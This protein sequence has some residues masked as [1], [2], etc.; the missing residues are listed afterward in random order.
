MKRP[1]VILFTSMLIAA[2]ITSA[3]TPKTSVERYARQYVYAADEGFDPHF[4]IKSPTAP[5]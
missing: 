1:S 3:C 2:V 4:R 5:G